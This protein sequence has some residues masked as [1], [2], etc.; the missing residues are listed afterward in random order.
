MD[1][2]VTIP[3][4]QYDKLVEDQHWLS[5]LAAAGVDNWEGYDQAIEILNS[6]NDE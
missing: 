3:K 6:D 1:E 5:C 2:T 4:E